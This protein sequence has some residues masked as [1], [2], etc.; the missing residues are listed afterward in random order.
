MKK[1]SEVAA[2]SAVE[3]PKA[4]EVHA[5][6]TNGFSLDLRLPKFPFEKSVP[7][8][9]TVTVSW[10]EEKFGIQNTYSSFSVGPFEMTGCVYEGETITQASHRLM[11][12]L[13]NFAEMERERKQT[14]FIDKLKSLPVGYGK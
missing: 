7:T 12:Q 5:P 11:A 3:T 10:A 1:R 4:E 13:V 9:E 8:N 6:G 2:V 14:S